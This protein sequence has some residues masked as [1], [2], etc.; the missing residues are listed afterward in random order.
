MPVATLLTDLDFGIVSRAAAGDDLRFEGGMVI[1]S[2]PYRVASFEQKR[3]V[4]ERNPHWWGKRP[5]ID[6]LERDRRNQRYF[7]VGGEIGS[8][9]WMDRLEIE[10][11]RVRHLCSPRYVGIRFFRFEAQGY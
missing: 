9:A 8:G 10:W 4:L 3:V 5:P 11:N 6:K 2:G 7:S 1:G